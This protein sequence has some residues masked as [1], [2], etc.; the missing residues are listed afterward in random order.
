MT[1]IPFRRCLA[2]VFDPGPYRPGRIGVMPPGP[3]RVLEEWW[4]GPLPEEKSQ[5]SQA[6]GNAQDQRPS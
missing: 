3:Y 1:Y 2:F 6:N 5:Q 4:E